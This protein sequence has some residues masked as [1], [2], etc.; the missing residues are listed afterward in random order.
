MSG[1]LRRESVDK[2]LK[3]YCRIAG[4]ENISTHILRHSFCTRLM[5][6]NVPIPVI[7]KL[8]GHSNIQTTINFYV[9]VSRQSKIEAVNKLSC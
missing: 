4:I 7:S 5:S 8:A 9:N 2:I 6:K 3:K 1:P